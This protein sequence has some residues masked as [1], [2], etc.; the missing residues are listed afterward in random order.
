[1]RLDLAKAG[2]SRM[3]ERTHVNLVDS[4]AKNVD[5]CEDVRRRIKSLAGLSR[6]LLR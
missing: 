6:G 3:L 2:P 5:C 1:M 4:C